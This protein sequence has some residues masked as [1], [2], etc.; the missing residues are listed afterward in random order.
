MDA[1]RPDESSCVFCHLIG[2][3]DLP[4]LASREDHVVYRNGFV[5]AFV[6]SHQWP[7]RVPNV[8]VVP[9]AHYRDLFELPIELASHIHRVVRLV[10]ESLTSVFAA[11]G[12]TVRQNNRSAGGQDVFHHHTHVLPRYERDPGYPT[13]GEKVAWDPEKLADWAEQ[14]RD[15]LPETDDK[16]FHRTLPRK[17]MGAG[18]IFSDAE[19]RVLIV[20]PT[21]KD[22]WEIP[23]GAVEDDESPAQACRREVGEE[24]GIEIESGRLLCVDY[25]S[26]TDVYLESLMFVFDGGRLSEEQVADISLDQN[27][28][29]EWRFVGRSEALELLGY[30]VSSRLRTVWGT[31]DPMDVAYL[32]DRQRPT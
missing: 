14:L 19:G 23:G 16:Q 27:E 2:G 1:Q 32:E 11:D 22:Y 29:S 7:G 31:S 13:L 10:A 21:Y 6:S 25:N 30:R 28:L 20:K 12:I 9:N 5:S 26:S 17:R 18:V 4:E 3:L 24:L 8:L 15:G